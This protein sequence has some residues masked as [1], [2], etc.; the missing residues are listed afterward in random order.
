MLI[1]G[2]TGK[3]HSGKDTIADYLVNN[4]RFI[5]IAFA[6]SLKLACKEVFGFSNNQLYDEKLKE[7]I[8]NDWGH[9]PREI[10]QKVGTE[11][12]RYALPKLCSNIH[13]DIWI[14]SVDKKI[15]N[16]INNTMDTDK[17]R[18]VITDIRFPNEH[19][20]VQDNNGL[21]LKILRNTEDQLCETNEHISEKN[22]DNFTFDYQINNN[23]T[24]DNLYKNVDSLINKIS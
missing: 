22:I 9:S 15:K 20:F 3:T 24:I 21:I 12:F 8:D 14:R 1:I 4:Y 2:L 11:L 7:E 19:K 17:L 10:F 16:I 23:S 6:D 13:D 18:I 5:K